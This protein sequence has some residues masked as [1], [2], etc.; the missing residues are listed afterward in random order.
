ME[1]FADCDLVPVNGL[2]PGISPDRWVFQLSTGRLVGGRFSSDVPDAC[3]WDRDAGSRLLSA[4]QFPASTCVRTRCVAGTLPQV[5]YS[6][7]D[8]GA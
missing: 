4:G 6:C 7:P 3:P 5:M 8:G 2:T 1:E